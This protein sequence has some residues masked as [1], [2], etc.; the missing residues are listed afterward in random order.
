MCIWVPFIPD[1]KPSNDCQCNPECLS[2]NNC[3]DDYAESCQT[4]V[5]RCG[6]GLQN[7]HPCQCNDKCKDFHDCCPDYDDIC[8]GGDSGRKFFE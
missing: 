5:D 2:H 6:N 3:C 8:I 1:Y 7:S 4:C